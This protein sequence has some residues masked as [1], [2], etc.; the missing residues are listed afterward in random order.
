[1]Q[2]FQFVQEDLDRLT[3]RVAPLPGTEPAGLEDMRLRIP[4]IFNRIVGDDVRVEVRFCDHI[5]TTPGGKHLFV[6]SKVDPDS[7][8]KREAS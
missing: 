6:V 7:W 5:E 1:V 3:V 2:Q 8:L 4:P